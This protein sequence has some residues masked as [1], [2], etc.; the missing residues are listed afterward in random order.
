MLTLYNTKM[1]VI[2]YVGLK[3]LIILFRHCD[4][5]ICIIRS[6]AEGTL[7]LTLSLE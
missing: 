5:L 1:W 2:F 4:Q 3:T 6:I 7:A